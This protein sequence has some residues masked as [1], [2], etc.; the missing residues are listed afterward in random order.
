VDT[1]QPEAS[2]GVTKKGKGE[3]YF[4]IDRR[5]WQILCGS[6]DV[7]QAATYLTIAQG[8]CKY[9]SKWSAKSVETYA[10]ISRLRA[11][12][13]ITQLVEKGFL[14]LGPKH[15]KAKPQYAVTPY[16]ELVRQPDAS[17]AA[18]EKESSDTLWLPST[19]IQGVT[20]KI[21]SPLCELV[22]T[23][24]ILPLRIL[25]DLYAEQNLV[26]D[27]GISRHVVYKA[28]KKE[29]VGER[30]E[31]VIWAFVPEEVIHRGDSKRWRQVYKDHKAFWSSIKTLTA[32][33][34]LSSVEH[35]TQSDSPDSEIVHALPCIY[36]RRASLDLEN[37]ISHAAAVAGW[38]LL[39]PDRQRKI[40]SG[41]LADTLLVPVQRHLPK[42]HCFGIYRLTHRPHTGLTA[43]WVLQN[44][45]HAETYIPM[46]ERLK[47]VGDRAAER[48]LDKYIQK[49]EKYA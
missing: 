39:T 32:L 23:Q 5:T 10:G 48:A 49:L 42:V 30:G 4:T 19:L 2:A 33:G 25:I 45:K 24:D 20:G 38:S 41:P 8:L 3:A 27:G 29:Q 7:N 1:S 37:R 35:L 26:A 28:Y 17:A 9:H 31:V 22:A 6:A 34:L 15:T 46:Y 40:E 16:D 21:A 12:K 47:V 11:A 13:Y 36:Y 18:P 43:E 44:Q 14:R